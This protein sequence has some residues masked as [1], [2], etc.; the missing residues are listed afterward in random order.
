MIPEESLGVIFDPDG[1]QSDQGST[2][3]LSAIPLDGHDKNTSA[4]G[5]S[6]PLSLHDSHKLTGKLF[7]FYLCASADRYL[8]TQANFSTGSQ[9]LLRSPI[10]SVRKAKR[11][12]A[13]SR[14]GF[15]REFDGTGE[16]EWKK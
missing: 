11:V 2:L 3:S 15:E 14:F 5:S 10:R 16:I 13:A 7:T 4:N 6:F 9:E 1:I 8:R 12:N